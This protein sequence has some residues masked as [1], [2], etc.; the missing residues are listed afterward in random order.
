MCLKKSKKLLPRNRISV[1]NGVCVPH[2]ALMQSRKVTLGSLGKVSG[3]TIQGGLVS[4][5]GGDGLGAYGCGV[6]G[7][8]TYN[9]RGIGGVYESEYPIVSI[10]DPFDKWEH[11][12]YISNL[13]ICQGDLVSGYGGDGLGAYGCGVEGYVT[14]DGPGIGGV[15]ESGSDVGSAINLDEEGLIGDDLLMSN[16]KRIEKAIAESA[17]NDL[18]LKVTVVTP[19]L[20]ISSISS[21]IGSSS[22]ICI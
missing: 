15:Y 6:E 21:S 3:G 7:Y 17:C 1:K 20:F 14:Y 2:L 13:G 8:V 4:G 10:E 11:I 16:A 5:Y 18:L 9:G 22:S 12:K 19:F